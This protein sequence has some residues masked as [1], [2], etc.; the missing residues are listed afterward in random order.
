MKLYFGRKMVTRWFLPSRTNLTGGCQDAYQL[1]LDNAVSATATNS[2][3][4]GK[5][6]GKAANP[7]TDIHN[8]P[9][10][11]PQD[12]DDHV[13]EPDPCAAEEPNSDSPTQ[14]SLKLTT[15]EDN[16]ADE[17][18]CQHVQATKPLRGPSGASA[19]TEELTL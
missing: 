5:A 12:A 6:V 16:L 18:C 13:G 19:R 8:E 14:S 3:Q 17:C 1:D 9:D 2:R 7:R 15:Q 10:D 11:S 4:D